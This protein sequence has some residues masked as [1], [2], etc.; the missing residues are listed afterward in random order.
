VVLGP[1]SF[2]KSRKIGEQLEWKV[3]GYPP[4]GCGPSALDTGRGM[5]KQKKC[6]F[7]HTMEIKKGTG[8]CPLRSP[9]TIFKVF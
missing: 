2:L 3:L 9:L 1:S 7:A 4:W 8:N 5:L 6:L